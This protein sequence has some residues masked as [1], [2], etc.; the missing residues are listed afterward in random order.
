LLLV[1]SFDQNVDII[2][3]ADFVMST[4]AAPAAVSGSGGNHV[5]NG[6]VNALTNEISSLRAEVEARVCNTKLE[7]LKGSESKIPVSDKK[8]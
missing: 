2:L 1:R 3:R 6:I 5:E 4:A 7:Q 8:R